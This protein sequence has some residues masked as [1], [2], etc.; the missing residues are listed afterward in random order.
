MRERDGA[1]RTLDSQAL[2][3]HRGAAAAIATLVM[4]SALSREFGVGWVQ[5]ADGHGREVTGV[6]QKLMEEFSSRRR[7]I[8]ALTERL[9]REFEA[10][11]GYAPDARALGRLR[12]W[13]NHAS[14][15][16]KEGHPLDLAA[17]ARRWAEQA[18]VSEAGALEPVLP[19]VSARQG[20]GS[21]A[22]APVQV[23]SPQ[24]ER[25]VISLALARVQ[26]A[27]PTWRKAD[28]IRHL[29]EL[30]PDDVAC[31]DD[32]A[33]AALLTGLADR[34]LAGG[35]SQRV[36]ALEAPEWPTVPEPLRRADGRSVYRPH[37]GTRYATLA[38]LTM[39]ERLT[40]LAQ[41]SG[42]PRLAPELA[43]CLLGADQAQLEAQLQAATLTAQQ[44][45]GT[46]GSG[47]RLDQAA[48][49]FLALTSDRRAEIL[50]G[51][52]GSGKTRTAGEVAR[53]WREAGMGQVYGLA[54]SQA[55][56]NVLREAGVDL[57]DNT[58]A[59]LGHLE[60]RREAL[61][62][63]TVQPGTLLVLD[64]ASMMSIADLAA[65]MRLAAVRDCRVL[66]TGDHEQLPAVEGGGGM[67]MLTR[68]MGYVQ[69]AEPVRFAAEWE[70]EATLRLRAGD[71]S[72]LAQYEEQGRL[73]GGD[74]E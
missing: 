63:K 8:T 46:T 70:R 25:K 66:I 44:A 57:A 48:A 55:A 37:S 64:E 20:A 7:T 52:A 42:A 67:M 65:I 49:A 16:F 38:Q 13:A 40:A 47:L 1:Y 71:A 30:L 9:A 22:P 39:E 10:Q 23:L 2:Y 51:P 33:A 69:L 27:Q 43:A 11:N 17:E 32:G 5:R 15:A 28:L 54:T 74:A 41:Q 62:P 19:A 26:E 21:P 73:R 24:Q 14:R 59:F 58:A 3:E 56:R 29:G 31:G 35:A 4:E 53:L 12:Q 50:V 6:S 18:C 68:Q 36:L 34:V 61:G 45:Q 60:G 72:V